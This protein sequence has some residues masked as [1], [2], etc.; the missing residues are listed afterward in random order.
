MATQMAGRFYLRKL[1]SFTY[2]YDS[3]IVWI[4]FG[5]NVLRLSLYYDRHY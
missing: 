1:V 4:L 2:C 5:F 3:R